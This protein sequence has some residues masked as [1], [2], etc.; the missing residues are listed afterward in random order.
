MTQERGSAAMSSMVRKA[1]NTET[2][3][4][5]NAKTALTTWWEKR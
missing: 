5:G 4:V 1:H 3:R 2:M